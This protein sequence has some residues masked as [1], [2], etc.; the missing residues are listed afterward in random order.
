[1]GKFKEACQDATVQ[2]KHL[3]YNNTKTNRDEGAIQ[4]NK[5]A[6]R[7]AMKNSACPAK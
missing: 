5:R 6:S 4:E 7:H 1:M 2:V 3:E